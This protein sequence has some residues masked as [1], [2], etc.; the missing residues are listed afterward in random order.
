[1]IAPFLARS[2]H[3]YSMMC[4]VVRPVDGSADVSWRVLWLWAGGHS[5]PGRGGH[6]QMHRHSGRWGH[7]H[8]QQL[9]RRRHAREDGI[10]QG[11]LQRRNT[12]VRTR[13]QI[14]CC[15][16]VQSCSCHVLFRPAKEHDATSCN[17]LQAALTLCIFPPSRPHSPS[18]G[19]GQLN[20][21]LL[22]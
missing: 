10:L 15:S 5:A 7:H 9:H 11:R 22:F 17:S 16:C 4:G 6:E 1:M 3:E 2:E 21:L 19:F 14:V 18:T 12:V 8:P 13:V 20:T